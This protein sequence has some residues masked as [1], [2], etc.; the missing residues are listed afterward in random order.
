MNATCHPDYGDLF[1]IRSEISP[2]V[3]MV[4]PK[5]RVYALFKSE[6]QSSKITYFLHEVML[7]NTKL[8]RYS[9]LNEITRTDCTDAHETTHG[10]KKDDP[11]MQEI[12]Q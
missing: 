11:L 2:Q 7:G 8:H 1:G 12:L 10:E 3:L 6:L 5:A 9:R 4:R